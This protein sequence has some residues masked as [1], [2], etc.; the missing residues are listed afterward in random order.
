MF[1]GSGMLLDAENNHPALAEIFETMLCMQDCSEARDIKKAAGYS[2]W[3]GIKK[4]L[5]IPEPT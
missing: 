5:H 2:S 1:F 3:I 4:L